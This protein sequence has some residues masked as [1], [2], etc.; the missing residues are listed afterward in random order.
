MKTL[1][2]GMGNPILSDDAIGI[3]LAT[4][5][6]QRLLGYP[7]LTVR[8]DCSVGGLEVLDVMAGYSRAIIIDS[9]QTVGGVPGQWH[10]FDAE[11]LRETMHLTNV[12]DANFATALELG[13]RLGI[14]LPKPSDICVFAVEA[15][16]TVTFSE[17]MT[18]ALEARYPALLDEILRAT[19]RLLLG[20]RRVG[21]GGNA[22]ART[23]HG[24]RPA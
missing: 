14:R 12:H 18:P 2:L 16:D 21:R 3:R 5:L 8:A 24:A 11:A 13:H 22:S 1:L 4:D 7:G 6:A 9:I 20:A 19:R 15:E 17:R 10:A 23:R